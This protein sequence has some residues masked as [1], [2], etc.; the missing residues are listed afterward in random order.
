M[1]ERLHFEHPEWRDRSALDLIGEYIDRLER[2]V[3][4]A[5]ERFLATSQPEESGDVSV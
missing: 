3:L 5:E 1:S 2:I 4:E